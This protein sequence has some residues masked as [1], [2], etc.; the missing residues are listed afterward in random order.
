MTPGTVLWM[1][2]AIAML[3]VAVTTDSSLRKR[4]RQ[5]VAAEKDLEEA[6]RDLKMMEDHELELT[7]DLGAAIEARNN[8]RKELMEASAKASVEHNRKE[9]KLYAELKEANKKNDDLG[10]RVLSLTNRIG[11]LNGELQRAKDSR[12]LQISQL[13]SELTE[14]RK[15]AHISPAV[16]H[17]A[18]NALDKV[19]VVLAKAMPADGRADSAW[20]P[21][22]AMMTSMAPV[23]RMCPKCGGDIGLWPEEICLCEWK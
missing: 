9:S 3:V 18:I 12:G 5:L 15:K 6:R 22:T 17:A 19:R 1:A 4:I 13:T 7:A 2:L 11:E 8:I 21:P 10:A 16:V 23:R 20:S 14:L